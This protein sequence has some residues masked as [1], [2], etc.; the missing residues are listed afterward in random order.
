VLNIFIMP[1]HPQYQGGGVGVMLGNAIKM[2]GMYESQQPAWVHRGILNHE[3]GHFLGLQHA[4]YSDGCDD[5][6]E[7]GNPCWNQTPEPPCDT[8]ASNNMMDYNALQN[9]LSPCQIGTM[10]ARMADTGSYERRYLITDW[11]T[12]QAE[13]DLLIADTVE[14]HGD[15]DLGGHLTI[16][17]GGLLRINGRVS[18][19]ENARITVLPGAVLQLGSRALLHNACNRQWEGIDAPRKFLGVRGKVMAETGARIRDAK[20]IDY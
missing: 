2:A 6:P 4:F 10:H 20:W 7:H 12:L 17:A 8:A 1:H 9:A 15:K 5:T 18:M 19:P 3:V 16:A 14:W 13:Q 11:C